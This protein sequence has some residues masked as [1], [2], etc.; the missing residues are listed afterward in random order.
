MID[1]DAPD[2]LIGY[3][4]IAVGY[5]VSGSDNFLYMFQRKFFVPF[6]N[7]VS[8]F[9]NYFKISFNSTFGADITDILLKYF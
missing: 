6:Q 9:T 5:S 2:K 4:I 1:N 7:S 8:G 3:F